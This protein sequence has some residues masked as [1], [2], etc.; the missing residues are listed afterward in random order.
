MTW[1]V[2][3]EDEAAVTVRTRCGRVKLRECGELLN[4]SIFSQMTKLFVYKSYV[5]S[6]LLYG[7]ESWCLIET[8][9]EFYEGQRDPW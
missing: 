5:R 2:Q 3:V 9:W 6:A 8:R 1:S 4:G 7:S